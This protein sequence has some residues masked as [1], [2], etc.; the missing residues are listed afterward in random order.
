MCT[1]LV[2]LR[3]ATALMPSTILVSVPFIPSVSHDVNSEIFPVACWNV[4]TSVAHCDFL[5]IVGSSPGDS[6]ADGP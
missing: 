6:A 5:Q 4:I 3:L 2:P 1:D